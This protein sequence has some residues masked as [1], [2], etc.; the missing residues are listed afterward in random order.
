[1]SYSTFQHEDQLPRLPVPSLLSTVEQALDA[2]EPLVSPDEYQ[3]LVE[4]SVELLNS[5]SVKVFQQ[6]LIEGSKTNHSYLDSEGIYPTTANVYGDLRGH[7]LPRNPFFIFENDPLKSMAPSQAFRASILVTSALRFA[8]A[9]RRE[10]L[11]PDTAPKSKTPLSMSSYKNLFGTTIVPYNNGVS[12]K[13]CSSYQDSRH[14]VIMARS[15]F[16]V[17]E[18]LSEDHQIW[19]TKHELKD[20]FQAIMDDVKLEHNS[21]T[22]DAIGALTT[23]LKS[24]WRNARYCLERTNKDA[25]DVLDNALF[26]VCLDHEAPA[27]DL[28]K[29]QFVSHG[30]SKI[31]S[32][33][34]QVGTCTNRYYDKLNLVITENSV[35]ACVYPAAAMDGT[36]VLRFVSDIYTDSV[37]RLARKING[38]NY[39]LWRNVN[40]VPINSDL[41]KPTFH[42]LEFSLPPELKSGLHLAETRLADII[43]QHEYV[44][45]TI[46]NIGSNFMVNKMNIPSDTVI[47]LAIQITYYALYGRAISTLEPVTTRKFRD[48][49]TEPICVQSSNVLALC[50]AFIS[51]TPQSRKW[52]LFLD[53]VEEHVAKIKN[54]AQGKGF[55]RHL[56]A[57]R[58]A[59]IQHEHLSKLNSTVHIDSNYEIPPFLFEPA[60]DLLYKPEILAAN[61]GN[62]ALHLFGVTPA[63]PS[64]FGIG[65]IIKE[66]SVS[67]VAS[68]QWRQTSRFLETLESVLEEIK[69]L[70]K[71]EGVLPDKSVDRSRVRELESYAESLPQSML[72]TNYSLKSSNI[73]GG[74]DYFDVEELAARSEQGTARHSRVQTRSNSALNISEHLKSS[75]K[76]I[77]V[78]DE[79]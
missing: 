40:T 35:A 63:I 1:M 18:V 79:L 54:A 5:Q 21:G 75:G 24:T 64:G 78:N 7:T 43:H 41:D 51:Q 37:L 34:L 32:D 44:S 67:I 31:D 68:S 52:A 29:V 70:W 30:T 36:S 4:K 69:V 57:L 49:R 3:N 2:L 6:Y 12:V 16:Y 72:S 58:S 28:E 20:V 47:Q 13:R 10:L 17:L 38:A 74:Y 9:L 27:N 76:R 55:E 39:T 65:Y 66:D 8:V 53:T 61:C 26:V 71:T 62:P 19:F 45:K 11:M 59:Y 33:G 56:S 23:E 14:I 73:L 77:S 46:T 50:Q 42:K 15:K 25:M 22:N 48:A 60:L